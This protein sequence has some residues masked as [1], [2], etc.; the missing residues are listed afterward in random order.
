MPVIKRIAAEADQRQQKG[1][2]RFW[3]RYSY[4]IFFM[5]QSPKTRLWLSSIFKRVTS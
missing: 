1:V 3:A 2:S 4:I 5:C